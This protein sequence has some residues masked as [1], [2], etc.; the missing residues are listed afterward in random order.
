MRLRWWWDFAPERPTAG[1]A[2]PLQL[3]LG[4][5]YCKAT[6]LAYHLADRARAVRC[7]TDRLNL[8]VLAGRERQNA[9]ALAR[10]IMG[11]GTP[12][13]PALF[14]VQRP[15]MLTAPKL[16]QDLVEIDALDDLYRQA[17]VL[18]TDGGLRGRLEA[19]GAEGARNSTLI[20]EI[21]DR[22]GGHVMDR[23]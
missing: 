6:A 20:R 8:E 9:A 12:Q 18:A 16:R 13:P 7:V 10:E 22:V 4:Q 14:P 17:C 21:L 23:A 11:G 2:E 1:Y 5:I 15:G 3:L 19:L